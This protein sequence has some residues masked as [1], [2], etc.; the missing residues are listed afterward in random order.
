MESLDKALKK[1]PAYEEQAHRFFTYYIPEM[2]RLV[3]SYNE[4]EKAGISESQMNP[5]YDKVIASI[6]KVRSAALQEVDDIYQMATLETMAKAE[7]LQKIIARDG[8]A[9]TENILKSE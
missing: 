8:Y 1:Y 5:V 6:Q 4:Y 9:D 7:A 3:F 2:M